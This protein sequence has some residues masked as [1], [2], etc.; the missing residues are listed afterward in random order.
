MRLRAIACATALLGGLSIAAQPAVPLPDAS[1]A[2]SVSQR[3]GVTDVNVNYHRPAVN[4]RR[5][6]GGLV[7]YGVIW[8]AG[9]NENT[10]ITFSTPVKVEGQAL[11]AGTYGLFM[12]PTEQQWTVVFSKFAGAWGTYTYDQSE[13]AARVTVTPE[14]KTEVAERMSFSFD[15]ISNTAGTL[16]LRWDKI[17][18]PVKIEVDLPTTIRA[19]IRDTLRTGKHWDANAWAS[20]ARWELRNGDAD[21][22]N[23]YADMALG[24]GVTTNT[25]RTKAAVLDKKG[26]AKGAAELR[27]RAKTIA[28]E[29]ELV[30]GTAYESIGAKKYDDAIAYL[31]G[32]IAAHATSDQLWRFYS[33]L[34][35]AYASKGDAAKSREALD[36]AMAMAHDVT[37][38]TEV[39]DS[40]NQIGAEMK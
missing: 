11:P 27:A 23:K 6:F 19:A 9:A 3:I 22:A 26:D 33:I 1:P 39:Q 17:R 38:R 8:R 4:K 15:D 16:A 28:N 29:A 21:T 7:P 18:V 37:E 35:E 14:T 12:I 2:A 32:Y 24:L 20:A 40:I 10:T 34:G 25:L 31:N 13:D 36:K 30:S 5:I